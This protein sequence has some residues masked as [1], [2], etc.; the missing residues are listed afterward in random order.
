MQQ[1]QLDGS[2]IVYAVHSLACFGGYD[3]NNFDASLQQENSAAQ[4]LMMFR[5]LV[6]IRWFAETNKKISAYTPQAQNDF[7]EMNL[8]FPKKSFRYFAALGHMIHDRH[9]APR[10]YPLLIGCGRHD[11]PMART[12]IE[13]WKG[14]E[15]RCR[16]IIFDDAGHC[17][18]M[19]VPQRFNAA[20]EEFWADAERRN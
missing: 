19:D 2:P 16:V 1:L 18:N 5:A 10:N 13:H 3:I 9:T 14:H 11:A 15:P 17:A 12:A 20:M 8:H 4:M 7:Y 6:S